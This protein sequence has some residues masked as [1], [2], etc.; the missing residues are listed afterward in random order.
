MN[1][2][3][4]TKHP[5]GLLSHLMISPRDL[6]AVVAKTS[7]GNRNWS[8]FISDVN[9][10]SAQ[11]ER[12]KATRIALCMRSSYAMAV[13]LIA[14]FCSKRQAIVPGNTQ[15][16][17]L[18]ALEHQWDL[19][20]HDGDHNAQNNAQNIH[21][22]LACVVG[23]VQQ[24]NIIDTDSLR[25]ILF[26]SG[27]SGTPKAISKSLKGIENELK[28]LE[29]QWHQDVAESEFA[30][31][32]S[33]QHIYGLLFRLLWPLSTGRPFLDR[34]WLYPEEV[35]QKSDAKRTLISS[36]ALLKRLL[37]DAS[38]TQFSAIFSSGGPLPLQAA[39]NAETLLGQ[40]PN[41]VFGSTETGGIAWRKQR[42]AETPWRLFK[43][44]KATTN[45]DHCLLLQSSFI[46]DDDYQTTDRVAF[47]DND[48][49]VLK[50]RADR[51]VKIEEKRISLPEIEHRL[52]HHPWIDEAAVIVL[53]ETGRPALGAVVA[54][55]EEGAN[56]RQVLSDAETWK[57]LR[58]YLR[59]WI[60]PIAI[61]RKF[62]VVR[63]LPV[64]AQGK[65]V[66]N[67]VLALF[68][69]SSQKA[70]EVR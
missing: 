69:P 42:T 54:L 43:G 19:F 55:T 39:S 56:E 44:H 40:R 57:T 53:N 17:A 37:L 21:T 34:D 66:R 10:L 59:E 26:T 23:P 33:H 9:N 62:R 58:A 52:A 70:E 25:L 27:S 48:T 45:D 12:Q 11:F 60:E 5:T 18:K 31:T 68:T 4:K 20:I 8:A 35:H 41:E 49:F 1:N 3:E 28:A 67:D 16:E 51:V 61:P 2:Q 36:P 63:H 65:L 22:L 24:T 38:P 46:E 15:T 13:A 14:C 32:V 29:Q 47:I 64:N 7:E 50:G 30:S 6:N